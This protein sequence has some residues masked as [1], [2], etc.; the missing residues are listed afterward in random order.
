MDR[1][2]VFS[3]IK[4]ADGTKAKVKDFDDIEKAEKY[5]ARQKGQRVLA[6]GNDEIQAAFWMLGANRDGESERSNT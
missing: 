1:I 6:I 5:M 2:K 3:W 4:N